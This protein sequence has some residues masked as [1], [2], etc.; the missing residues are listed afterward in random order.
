VLLVQLHEE[1]ALVRNGDM[2]HVWTLAELAQSVPAVGSPALPRVF[3]VDPACLS[4]M[5]SPQVCPVEIRAPQ[6]G[7]RCD[8]RPVLAT[9]RQGLV[10]LRLCSQPSLHMWGIETHTHH[11]SDAPSIEYARNLSRPVVPTSA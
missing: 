8:A 5:A 9:L 4:S 1:V 2:L 10:S 11:Q 7:N 6:R 3:R